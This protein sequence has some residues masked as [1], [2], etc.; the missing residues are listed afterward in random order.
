VPFVLRKIRK[1]KWYKHQDVPWLREGELQADALSDFY[2]ENNTLS[3][4]LVT[5]DRLNLERIAAALAA[6][7]DVIS[8]LDYTLLNV[9]L[10]DDLNIKIEP[11]RGDSSD[12]IANTSWHRDLIELSTLNLMGLA[13]TILTKGERARYTDKPDSPVYCTRH[14]L[15]AARPGSREAEARSNGKN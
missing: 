12:Q 8:N 3:I 4:W 9:R 1:A 13:N 7:R 11:T 14:C 5:D 2:T 6:N 15:K 10:L